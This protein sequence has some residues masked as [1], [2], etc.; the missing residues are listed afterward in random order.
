VN[1]CWILV[2]RSAEVV[3]AAS[4]RRPEEEELLVDAADAL[5]MW[6]TTLQ[7]EAPANA[8]DNPSPTM[9][10]LVCFCSKLSIVLGMIVSRKEGLVLVLLMTISLARERCSLNA[11]ISCRRR[12][13]THV[14]AG[15]KSFNVRVANKNSLDC[16]D[17]GA[18]Q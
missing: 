16:V 10:I 13:T 5:K 12:S 14:L 6:R 1:H 15:L 3:V 17:G 11:K 4:G 9:P 2:Q 8:N 7:N 18:K